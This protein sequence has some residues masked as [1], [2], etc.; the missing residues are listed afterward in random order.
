MVSFRSVLS[1][2][3]IA[4]DL[5]CSNKTGGDFLWGVVI[6]PHTFYSRMNCYREHT[7][8]VERDSDASAAGLDHTT[9]PFSMTAEPGS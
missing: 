7:P 8:P 5:R 3:S 9:P 2:L 6:A 1:L 4:R